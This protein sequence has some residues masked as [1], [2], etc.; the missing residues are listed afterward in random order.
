MIFHTK[1]DLP[2]ALAIHPVFYPQPNTATY[3]DIV[4]SKKIIQRVSTR[5]DACYAK[6]YE[7]CH[8]REDYKMLLKT[9][10][11]HISLLYSGHHLDTFF[12]QK[13]P[14]CSRNVTKLFLGRHWQI[15]CRCFY[16]YR[17]ILRYYQK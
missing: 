2:D 13:Y 7:A 9:Y 6:R 15:P 1:N 16:V 4:F 17:G 11:C 3:F 12:E 5:N 14:E 10:E 8:D